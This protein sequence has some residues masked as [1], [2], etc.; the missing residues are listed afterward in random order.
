MNDPKLSERAQ[1]YLDNWTPE[2][3]AEF[4]AAQEAE[5][6]ALTAGAQRYDDESVAPTPGQWIML[7]NRATKEQRL[8]MA[9]QVLDDRARLA[10][11]RALHF[12]R[13]R[14]IHGD[15]VCNEC[16]PLQPMPCPTLRALDGA[17]QLPATPE[18]LP[19]EPT[20]AEYCP[21]C[22]ERTD[23]PYPFLCPGHPAKLVDR[24]M[25]ETCDHRDPNRLGHRPGNLALV[26]A[27]GETVFPSPLPFGPGSAPGYAE[28]VNAPL[29]SETVAAIGQALQAGT[30]P[31]WLVPTQREEAPAASPLTAL[32]R[33]YTTAD[34]QS[35]RDHEAEGIAAGLTA[36]GFDVVR[37]VPS[38]EVAANLLTIGRMRAAFTA[39]DDSPWTPAPAPALTGWTVMRDDALPDGVVQ[40]RPRKP[41]PLVHES[42]VREEDG[43]WNVSCEDCSAYVDN[44]GDE[45]DAEVWAAEHREQAAAGEA[46]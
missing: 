41:A 13:G 43:E 39:L 12:T 17:Q 20:N 11:A 44:I 31:R 26:C 23:L 36:A 35:V 30:A 42:W 22:R 18:P 16:S 33:Q 32:I 37:T 14:N 28:Q 24:V 5:V 34:F 27:C 10:A 45:A 29:R 19:A 40:F 7:F 21:E 15:S 9:A 46:S 6:V 3:V 1:W 4:A 25:A 38:E 2:Q 8:A